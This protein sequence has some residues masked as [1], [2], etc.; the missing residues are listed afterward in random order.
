MLSFYYADI[1]SVCTDLRDDD[2][3]DD[4]DGDGDGRNKQSHAR[5]TA[6]SNLR[7]TA[8]STF[9]SEEE[10]ANTHWRFVD[11]L[12]EEGCCSRP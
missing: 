11:A 7:F 5:G 4:G 6:L 1:P 8:T 9:G 2:D 3:D 10:A 12:S